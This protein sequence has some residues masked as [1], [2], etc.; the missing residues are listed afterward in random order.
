V[1]HLGKNGAVDTDPTPGVV[2]LRGDSLVVLAGPSGAGKSSW[3]DEWFRAGQVVSADRLR[4]VVGEHEQDLRASDDAFAVLDDIVAKRLARGLL[5]VVDTLG[6]DAER[7]RVWQ[8]I[9]AR[10]GRPTHLVRFDTDAA[11]CRRR[12]KARPGAV[13]AR[14]LTSQLAKWAETRDALAAGF[15]DVH[16]PGP[17]RIVPA[18]LLGPGGEAGSARRTLRFGLSIS[19][20]DWGEDTDI[21]DRLITIAAE[22]ERVGFESIWVMDHFVQ[23][24]QV[25]REWEPMLEAYTVLAHLAAT[26]TR[27]GLGALVTCITHRNIAHLGK[28][29]ATL[30]V[31]SRGRARC[32]LGLGW[33]EREHRAFGYE[34]PSTGDRYALLAD[35]LEFLPIQWGPGSPAFEGRTFSTPEAIGYPRPLQDRVPILVG[36]SGERRTLELVARYADACNLFGEPD[37]VRHKV[38]VLERHCE[39]VGR[40]PAEV[41]VTQLSTVLAASDRSDLTERVDALRGGISPEGYV[42]RTSA[43][44]VDD[45]LERF[46]RLA[47][48]GVDTVIVSLADL[49][50]DGAVGNFAPIIDHFRP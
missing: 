7:H 25:G 31:L 45:H 21:A 29:I 26:T 32:G 19:S 41:S 12:N 48:A 6:M 9:A 28:I 1:C 33:F 4:G 27:A 35:A 17:V 14:V 47:D 39:A 50:L 49:A 5:T 18:T 22:A 38:Q 30:D 23:I 10:H 43:A 16:E 24:P 34:F 2:R 13:P 46:G 8:E 3:A 11:T 37:V 36:G 20:F 40:D 44:V 15:D 42:E